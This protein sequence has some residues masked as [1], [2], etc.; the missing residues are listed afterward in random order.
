MMKHEMYEFT[1]VLDGVDDQTDGLED[2]LFE[3]Q[4]DDALINF[5]NGTVYLDFSRKSTSI[6]ESI[7]SAIQA[8]E[9]VAAGPK[10]ISILPDDLVTEAEI[11]HRLKKTRQAVS[12]WVKKAR[13][14]ENPFPNPVSGLSDKSPMWRWGEVVQWLHVHRLI[15]DK[16]ILDSATFIEHANAVLG[17]R[18]PKIKAYRHNILNRLQQPTNTKFIS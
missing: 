18:D 5:R 14:Q 4:C 8:G 10:V 1:L 3:A 6:E 11:A 13:R 15:K 2:Q 16:K 9:R 7:I 12:L 17:E